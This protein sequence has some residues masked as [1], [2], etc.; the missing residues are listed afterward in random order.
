MSAIHVIAERLIQLTKQLHWLPK[1]T[2][3]FTA[4]DKKRTIAKCLAYI[5]FIFRTVHGMIPADQS[6]LEKLCRKLF[7]T[8]NGLQENYPGP[9]TGGN[10]LCTVKDQNLP[11]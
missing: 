9:K 6:M 10:I 7:W 8:F 1:V 3:H 2:Q 5:T 4:T 11:F